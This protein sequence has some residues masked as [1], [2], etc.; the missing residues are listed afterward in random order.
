M[1]QQDVFEVGGAGDILHGVAWSRDVVICGA[2]Q[3]ASVYSRRPRE[4]VGR[5][6]RVV[7]RAPRLQHVPQPSYRQQLVQSG[8]RD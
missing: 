2:I 1:A 8:L 4:V 6:Y 7:A 3:A 5:K